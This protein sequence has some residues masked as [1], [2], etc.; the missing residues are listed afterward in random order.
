MCYCK[1]EAL[2]FRVPISFYGKG[3]SLAKNWVKKLRE[4][5]LL[6]KAELARKAGLS[7]PTV[8]R[9]EKGMDCRT[10]TKRKIILALDLELSDKNKVFGN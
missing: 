7:L 10:E 4:E 8:D 9:L 3:F 6:S 2:C 5:R 1:I